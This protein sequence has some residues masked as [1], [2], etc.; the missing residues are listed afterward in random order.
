MKTE[1]RKDVLDRLN[2]LKIVRSE[3]IYFFDDAIR[4]AN[5]QEEIIAKQHEALTL[6]AGHLESIFGKKAFLE[7]ALSLADAPYGGEK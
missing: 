6:A 2:G 3:Y 4:L 7:K 5:A 1:S